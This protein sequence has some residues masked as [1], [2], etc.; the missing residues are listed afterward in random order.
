MFSCIVLVTV[1]SPHFL[2]LHS[3]EHEE[4]SV[5]LPKNLTS[6][7]ILMCSCYTL[8]VLT[9]IITITYA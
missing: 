4:F 1:V 5:T 7:T 9:I 2:T 3:Q 6:N 8:N